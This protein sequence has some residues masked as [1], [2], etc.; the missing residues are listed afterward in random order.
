M[1]RN[2]FSVV[3]RRALEE[4][5]AYFIRRGLLMKSIEQQDIEQMKRNP[6]GTP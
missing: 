1:V 5:R 4:L 3:P 6:P 2:Q